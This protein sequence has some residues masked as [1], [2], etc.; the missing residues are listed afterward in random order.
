[1]FLASLVVV[2]GCCFSL[3]FCREIT[4]T[5]LK[6]AQRF[7]FPFANTFTTSPFSVFLHLNTIF[8]AFSLASL[9]RTWVDSFFPQVFPF[10]LAARPM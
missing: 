1:M 5:L 6:S 2:S 7:F 3:T 10:T 4:E 9:R 8:G